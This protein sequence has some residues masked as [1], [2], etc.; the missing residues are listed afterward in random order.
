[1]SARRRR[2][3]A[4]VLAA[5]ATASLVA[6]AG[7]T[8]TDLGPWYQSLRKPPWQ[9]PDWLFGPAWTVIFGLAA[10]AFVKAWRSAPDRPRGDWIIVLFSVN[11]VLNI[12][13]SALFFRVKRPDWAFIEVLFLWASIV[14]LIVMVGRHS[15]PAAALLL[16]YLAWVTFAAALNLSVARLNGAL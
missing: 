11:G 3:W 15:R 9:P 5:A 1:M 6:L 8:M 10:A 2:R 16:P 7:A 12:L 13:W 4:P 14:L